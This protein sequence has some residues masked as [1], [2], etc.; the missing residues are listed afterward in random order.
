[1]STRF[2]VGAE[3]MSAAALACKL[4]VNHRQIDQLCR[5]GRII[6]ASKHP[7]TKKWWIYPPAILRPPGG[8]A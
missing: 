3:G 5:N 4:N 1:M 7:L 8:W 2:D 6:G